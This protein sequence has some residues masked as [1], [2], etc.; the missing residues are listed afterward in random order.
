VLATTPARLPPACLLK[1]TMSGGRGEKGKGK[2]KEAKAKM[3]FHRSLL[4]SK[5][6]NEYFKH[7]IH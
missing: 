2:K 1:E 4:S 7:D 3:T 5:A 6:T